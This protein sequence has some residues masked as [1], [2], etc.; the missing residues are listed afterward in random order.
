MLANFHKKDYIRTIPIACRMVPS[1][2]L[3][4]CFRP[5]S[6]TKYN[7]VRT[8]LSCRSLVV[9]MFVISSSVIGTVNEMEE[10]NTLYRGISNFEM[11]YSYEHGKL[12]CHYRISTS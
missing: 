2:P 4:I 3:A 12:T 8:A 5:D 6:T 7:V 10:P 11:I 1:A 9:S